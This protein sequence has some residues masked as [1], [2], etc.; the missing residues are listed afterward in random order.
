VD[1][2]A[3]ASLAHCFERSHLLDAVRIEVMEL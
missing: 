2:D 3:E 1:T